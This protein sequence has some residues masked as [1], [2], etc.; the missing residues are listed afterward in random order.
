MIPARKSA[1]AAE[2]RRIMLAD[3]GRS[4][5]EQGIVHV[6]GFGRWWLRKT[7]T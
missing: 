6:G 4:A 1:T 5:P 7:E 3:V 2:M